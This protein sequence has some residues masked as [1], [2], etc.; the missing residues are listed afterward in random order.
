MEK[1]DDGERGLDKSIPLMLRGTSSESSADASTVPRSY[2]SDANSTSAHTLTGADQERIGIIQYF[3]CA[4]RRPS[5][6]AVFQEQA[7]EA[8]EGLLHDDEAHDG[9][10]ESMFEALL[11]FPMPFRRPQRCGK[12]LLAKVVFSLYQVAIFAGILYKWSVFK[13]IQ[14]LLCDRAIGDGRYARYG[15][16]ETQNILLAANLSLASPLDDQILAIRYVPAFFAKDDPAFMP[17]HNVSHFWENVL[18]ETGRTNYRAN[19]VLYRSTTLISELGETL[20]SLSVALVFPAICFVLRNGDRVLFP[21]SIARKGED[22]CIEFIRLRRFGIEVAMFFGIPSSIIVTLIFYDAWRWE[23]YLVFSGYF[24]VLTPLLAGLVI[25]QMDNIGVLALSLA[26]C[27][28]S[29]E[30]TSWK[31]RWYKPCVFML[32]SWSHEVSLVTIAVA[33][34]IISF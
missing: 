21:P 13:Y 29:K 14:I 9:K 24:V 5:S 34:L 31:A 23:V 16:E 7:R 12:S 25:I 20:I 18:S 4:N 28:T 15:C 26:Q 17:V 33:L 2:L 19:F 3:Q 10:W 32:R 30:I 27:K 6:Y 1:K 8:V 11:A 22:G